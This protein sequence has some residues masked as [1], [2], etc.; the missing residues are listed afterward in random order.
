[1]KTFLIWFL[2]YR[3][4][5]INEIKHYFLRKLSNFRINYLF[6][7]TNVFQDRLSLIAG[8]KFCKMHSAIV[9]TF[10]KLPVVIKTVVLSI[11]SNLFTQVLLYIK[12]IKP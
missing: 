1:M 11:L 7:N 12:I 9:S 3:T 2:I 4:N 8:Q 5:E 6:C 10:I